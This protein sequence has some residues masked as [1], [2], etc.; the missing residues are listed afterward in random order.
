M[1]KTPLV[2]SMAAGV[3]VLVMA[4][5]ASM[6]I[7]PYDVPEFVEVDSSESAFL[8]PLEGDLRH[9]TA[10]T[11]PRYYY[12]PWKTILVRTV[13]DGGESFYIQGDHRLTVPAL[14]HA[15]LDADRGS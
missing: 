1:R 2:A 12:R 13:A 7:R 4:L 6:L 15:I 10:K 9:E 11:D 14:Y 5:A 3:A 8:I